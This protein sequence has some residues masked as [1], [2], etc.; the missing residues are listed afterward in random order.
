MPLVPGPRLPAHARRVV[1]R[2]V[3]ALALVLCLATVAVVANRTA[4]L[5]GQPPT[6]Q[7]LASAAAV[8]THTLVAAADATTRVDA[9]TAKSGTGP[10]LR[11]DGAPVVRSFLRFDVPDAGPIQRATLQ[12]HAETANRVGFDVRSATG[13]WLERTLTHA[14]APTV[15]PM[16]GSSGRLSAGQDV[17]VD[18]TALAQPGPC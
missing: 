1:R 14:N 12:L 13:N 17:S 10:S 11:V 18:V 6:S 2:S 5:A 16:V 3:L 15:G 8:T 4:D 7:L 9:P